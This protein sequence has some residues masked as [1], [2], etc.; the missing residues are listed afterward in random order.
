MSSITTSGP[1]MP[2]MVQA[3]VLP[4][5]RPFPA[6]SGTTLTVQD[7]IR[8]LKRFLF[9]ILGVFVFVLT[10]TIVGTLIWAKWY[11]SYTATALVEVRSPLVP[12]AMGAET[13]Y[14]PK[15]IIEQAMNTQATMIRSQGILQLALDDPLVKQTAW[16]NQFREGG[17]NANIDVTRALL[18]MQ[19]R[20]SSYAIRD[21]T[22]VQVAFSWRTGDE[23]AKIINVIL[24][25]YYQEVRKGS[26]QKTDNE[27][28]QYQTRSDTL[29]EELKRTIDEQ[30]RFR[31]TYNIPLLEQRQVSMGDQV[32]ALT[33]LLAQA[34]TE[35]DQAQ[36]LFDMYNQPGA[37]ERMAETPEMR[38]LVDND[39]F[40]RYYTQMLGDYRIQLAATKEKGPSNRTVRELESRIKMVEKE[41]NTKKREVLSNSYQDMKQRTQV[42]LDTVITQ[43]N[44]LQN[45]LAEA[46][47]ELSELEKQLAAYRTQEQKIQ[48]LRKQLEA[49]DDW[50]LKLRIQQNNPELVRVSI[51]GF[52]NAAIEPLQR[53]SPKWVVN[54]P[55]GVVLGLLLGV[56]LAFLLE[57]MSTTVKTP[58]DVLRQL[59]LP[60]LGQIPS[61]DEDEAAA[62]DMRRLILEAPHSML[63]ESFRQ[64]RANFLF[65]APA[66]HQRSILVTSCSPSEGKTCVAVNLAL[67]LALAGRKILLVDTNFRRP[68]VAPAFGLDGVNEGLSN[69]LIGHPHPELLIHQTPHE[70]LDI[71]AAGPLPP[72]PAE[73]LSG[74]YLKNFIAQFTGKYQTIIFDGPPVLVV[75]DAVVLATALDGVIMVVRAGLTARGAIQRAKDQLRRVNGKILGVVLNDVKVTRGGYFREMYKTY[76]EYQSRPSFE[77]GGD[78]DDE[79]DALA[80]TPDGPPPS[81]AE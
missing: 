11:P 60:L 18:D 79:A 56:G 22:Y 50:V 41:L 70:N 5:P 49:V 76:Y 75:S 64:L 72:N 38:Q 4:G 6:P 57:F 78:A 31:T 54:L 81:K 36:S 37:M 7:V 32:A 48:S 55:A 45:R 71:L 61:Q 34:M 28:Q 73:L 17:E 33:Q 24:D 58:A 25:K 46:K 43:V 23:S 13:T 74:N 59:N 19:D 30:E 69:I 2:P 53:S 62:E 67:S 80:R 66:D 21:T 42:Q 44:G 8:V 10:L 27:L 51:P 47:M 15:E 20:L 16:Y 40:V 68:T 29:R 14:V 35:K 39:P 12:Q 26:Q 63:A 1:P 52:P 9:L 65:C 3:P 77:E